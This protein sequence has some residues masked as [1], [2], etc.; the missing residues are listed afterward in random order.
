[1]KVMRLPYL[2][3][4]GV[5]DSEQIFLALPYERLLQQ[6]PKGLQGQ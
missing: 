3:E 6:T 2:C 1:M 4:Q 5:R